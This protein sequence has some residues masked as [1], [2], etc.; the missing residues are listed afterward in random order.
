MNLEDHLRRIGE[1]L[2]GWFVART[3]DSLVVGAAWW[4]GLRLL[5]VPL[6]PLWAVLAALLQFVPHIGPA[7]ALVGPAVAAAISG[8]E[9]RFFL[10]LAVYAGI[11]LLN[12]LVIEPL[13]FK[14]VAHIPVWASLVVPVVLGLAFSFWGV[15]LAAPLLAIYFSYRPRPRRPMRNGPRQSG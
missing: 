14:R 11:T 10:V 4:V 3:W 12:G 6:A 5:H 2:W 13:F 7:M 8:G 15:I 9:D 1:A